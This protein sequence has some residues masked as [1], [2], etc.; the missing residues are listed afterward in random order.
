M[1]RT[2]GLRSARRML[3]RF[4]ALAAALLLA[5]GLCFPAQAFAY[6]SKPAVGVYLGAG[7]VSLTAGQSTTVSVSVD[8][9]SEQQLPGCG[10]AECPQAC[11]GLVNPDTGV[12]GGCLNADGW[13]TCAGTTYST[14]YTQLSVMSSNP[15]VARATVSG[16]SLS[17]QAYS[18][19]SATL[20][21]YSS[22]SKHQEGS[23]SMTVN[24]SAASSAGSGGSAP[25][26]SGSTSPGS[27]T[28]SAASG[29]AGAASG[30]GSTGGGVS[31]SA[32]GTSATAAAA[33]A[34][35]ASG[36]EE[37]EVVEIEAEDGT[38]TLVVE[39]KDAKTAEESLREVAGTEGTVTFWS[40]GT[41]ESPSIS[42]TFNGVD[43]DPE[44]DLSFDPTVVV[45]S[46]GTGDVAALLG[47]VDDAIVMDFAFSG[48]LPA[49]AQVYVRAS[50][51][52]DDGAVVDLY[53]Y[54]PDAQCF[55]SEQE[56]I[57]VQD[58]YAVFTLE[59][60]SVWALSQTDLSA[61]E[62]PA[63]AAADEVDASTVN[64]QADSGA[65]YLVAIGVVAAVVVVAVVVAL[66][67]R[68]RRKAAAA[69]DDGEAA[70]GEAGS[71]DAEAPEALEGA[72]G[73]AADAGEGESE[74]AAAGSASR[75]DDA[76]GT[77]NE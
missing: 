72:A 57:E 20:T 33:A 32:A 26:G 38:K 19:G 29:S 34:V 69:A 73:D 50:G 53:S 67:V 45:N 46:S 77:G 49:P 75:R 6:F 66:A 71:A 52:Y 28:G 24:V 4:A 63:D 55:Q 35:E 59:H 76:D 65:P 25:T 18:A 37:R 31:V 56:G 43:L 7:S 12:L 17:I 11:S 13:C 8:M 44:G 30:S 62:M 10:M 54:D 5:C 27:G 60:C 68:S 3:A 51:V 39:A 21:V 48:Q 40:G 2:V 23:A 64:V 61:L 1:L 14:Y 16:S 15:S 42:W 47:D 58:S 9:W 41:L 22:L 74:P 36:G 70:A